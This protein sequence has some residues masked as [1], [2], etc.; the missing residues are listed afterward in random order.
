[1]TR[2]EVCRLIDTKYPRLQSD[3]REYLIDFMYS[4]ELAKASRGNDAVFVER[5]AIASGQFLSRVKFGSVV[6]RPVME[7][8]R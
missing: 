7:V 6:S 1:M 2:L 8:V 4:A 5:M 3:I